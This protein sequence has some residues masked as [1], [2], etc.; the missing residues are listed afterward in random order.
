MRVGPLAAAADAP[1][2]HPQPMV[3]LIT[4]TRRANGTSR[5]CKPSFYRTWFM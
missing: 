5:I 2:H 3:S 1:I 4:L